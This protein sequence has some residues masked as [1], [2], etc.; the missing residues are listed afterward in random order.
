MVVA[1]STVGVPAV[2][3]APALPHAWASHYIPTPSG[4]CWCARL[5]T[6]LFDVGAD[7]SGQSFFNKIRFAGAL[8]SPFAAMTITGGAKDIYLEKFGADATALG[9]LTSL[10][11]VY[12]IAI[13]ILIGALQ[14]RSFLAGCFPLGS[15]GRRAP[16]FLT[17]SFI[18]AAASVA[19]YLPPPG[20]DW[21]LHSWFFACCSVGGYAISSCLAAITAARNEIFPFAEERIMV[22]GLSKYACMAGGAAGGLPLVILH[23]DATAWIRWSMQLYIIPVCLLSLEAVG[24]LREANAPSTSDAYGTT[25]SVLKEAFCGAGA[26]DAFRQMLLL[27]WWWGAYFGATLTMLFYYVTYNMLLTGWERSFV[28]VAASMVKSAVETVLNVVVM[29]FF[30]TGGSANGRRGRDRTLLLLVI[31]SRLANAVCT[32]TVLGV[33]QPSVPLFVAWSALYGIFTSSFSFW[34]V[35]AED[36]VTDEDC[37]LGAVAGRRRQATLFGAYG[38][39]AAA[40]YALFSNSLFLGLGLAGLETRNCEQEC[41]QGLFIATDASSGSGD[42]APDCVSACL[43]HMVREQPDAV[44]QYIQVVLGVVAPCLELL[45]ALHAYLMPIKGLRLCRLHAAVASH[46]EHTGSPGTTA[47]GEQPVQAEP[48]THTPPLAQNLEVDQ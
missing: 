23:A 32:A 15:W 3:D 27:R 47:S 36:W 12:G 9:V 44:R 46:R 8:A 1:P 37:Y 41:E 29:Y 42:D 25:F 30:G 28:A 24:R 33:L 22:E 4:R 43:D 31:C 10:L 19:M 16:W 18:A 14:D 20:G 40:G 7:P 5:R 39:A 26:N 21:L 35:A 11:S 13:N 45:V 17:H 38:M 48:G 34:R 6:F 2:L